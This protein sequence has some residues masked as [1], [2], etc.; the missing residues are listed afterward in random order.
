MKGLLIGGGRYCSPICRGPTIRSRQIH[1]RLVGHGDANAAFVRSLKPPF[2]RKHHSQQSLIANPTVETIFAS[3]R[4]HFMHRTKTGGNR[5]QGSVEQLVKQW[6]SIMSAILTL[7]YR[8]YCLARL[9]EMRRRHL[10]H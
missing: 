10:A 6:S 3:R 7:F 4:N 2:A 8:A 1:L 9:T 5:D